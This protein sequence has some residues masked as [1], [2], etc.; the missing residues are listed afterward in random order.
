[1]KKAPIPKDRSYIDSEQRDLNPRPTAPKAAALAKLRYAPM[2]Q[3][4]NKI[5]IK[6]ERKNLH[7]VEERFIDMEFSS[8]EGVLGIALNVIHP[9]RNRSIHELMLSLYFPPFGHPVSFLA[10]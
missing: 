5:S 10:F 3:N 8:P 9:N 4:Y 1:M 2:L 6:K 7:R